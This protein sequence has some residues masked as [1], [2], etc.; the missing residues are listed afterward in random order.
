MATLVSFTKQY[1]VQKTLRFELI[2]QG[3]TQA[4]I[5]AK[6][7]INDDLKRDENYMKVKGVIDELHKNFIEQTLVN[8]D[9]DWRSLATAIKNYRKDRSDTNKKNLEKTSQEP[10]TQSILSRSKYIRYLTFVDKYRNLTFSDG[11]FVE[12]TFTANAT[13][14]IFYADAA[15]DAKRAQAFTKIAREMVVNSKYAQPVLLGNRISSQPPM[16]YFQV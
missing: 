7:F 4:N 14:D 6:G 9:Y 10:S 15:A 13:E 16:S 8:V 12:A 5:D 3:K 2:P 11:K 1:Q